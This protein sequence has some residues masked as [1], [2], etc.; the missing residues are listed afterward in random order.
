M[1]Q[2][3]KEESAL[4]AQNKHRRDN[5]DKENQKKNFGKGENR[6][7]EKFKEGLHRLESYN[8]KQSIALEVD[9]RLP[10]PNYVNN[11]Q[12]AMLINTTISP[13]RLNFSQDSSSKINF[14]YPPPDLANNN[15][16]SFF[17]YHVRNDTNKIQLPLTPQIFPE[18]LIQPNSPQMQFQ[19]IE[20]DF[21]KDEDLDKQIRQL[22]EERYLL[23]LKFE[24]EVH[25]IV[26]GDIYYPSD[27]NINEVDKQSQSENSEE[28]KDPQSKQDE[29]GKHIMMDKQYENEN[30]AKA[31]VSL[32]KEKQQEKEM[33]KQSQSDDSQETGT[34]RP[35]M[36]RAR[37]KRDKKTKVLQPRKE[38]NLNNLNEDQ[39]RNLRSGTKIF[40]QKPEV[41]KERKYTPNKS[42]ILQDN[43][44]SHLTQPKGEL[45]TSKSIHVGLNVDSGMSNH[46][47]LRLKQFSLGSISFQL[48]LFWIRME[49][50]NRMENHQV[51][52]FRLSTDRCLAPKVKVIHSKE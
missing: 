41:K 29:N 32:M 52:N 47:A 16:L 38:K 44:T 25:D 11:M 50:G 51:R 4:E 30:A 26:F 48:P 15:Q 1:I 49:R 35:R 2:T 3:E 45:L 14:T 6:A 37:H 40:L 9:E 28:T 34:T 19:T 12:D 24:F 20:V 43:H 10:L 31:K 18:N 13:L 23:R 42:K 21:Q 39:T 17:E 33:D 27:L 36:K 5:L 22:Q 8:V 7:A 46:P